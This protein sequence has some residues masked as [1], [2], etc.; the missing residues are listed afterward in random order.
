MGIT[1]LFPTNYKKTKTNQK[2]PKRQTR[3][4]MILEICL[5]GEVYSCQQIVKIIAEKEGLY[6]KGS[7]YY[8][9]FRIVSS[10][11]NHMVKKN[12]LE[13]SINKTTRG[14]YLYQMPEKK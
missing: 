8:D 4:E 13:Y 5:D 10:L 6:P 9:L 12:Q 2:V 1:I 7:V 3:R 11:L 14:G